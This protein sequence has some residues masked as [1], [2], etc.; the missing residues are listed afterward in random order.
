VIDL[1]LWLASL[2]LV[3]DGHG[4]AIPRPRAAVATIVEAANASPAPLLFAAWLDVLAAHESGYRTSAAGDCPGLSAGSR[5]CTRDR[6]AHAC[7]AWQGLCA[8]LPPK[9]T[10]LNQALLAVHDLVRAIAVCPEHPL[11]AYASGHCARTAVAVRYE[12]DVARELAAS[13]P[14]DGIVANR[15]E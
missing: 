15:G 1:A 12:A 13:I 9:A 11:W 6:G 2:P 8:A 14:V 5:E 3:L 4:H 7:G 10:P